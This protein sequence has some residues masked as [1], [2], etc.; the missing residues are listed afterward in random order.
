MYQPP[1]RPLSVA[2]LTSSLLILPACSGGAAPAFEVPWPHSMAG[3]DGAL[4]EAL[5]EAR[6]VVLASPADAASWV[7][8]GMLFEAHLQL[9][10]AESCYGE[11]VRLDGAA[12][13]S[14]YR[15]AAMRGK[16]G[17]VAEALDALARV[18]ALEPGYGPAWRRKGWLLLADG[19]PDEAK[20]AFERAASLDPTDSVAQ[21]GQV[22]SEL[23]VGDA[24][25]A[26]ARL[27]RLE[28]I[29]PSSQA[30]YHRL[31]GRA[32][33]GLG[34]F[35]EAEPELA[36]GR[37]A[38][39]GG[40]DPWMREVNALKIGE[41]AILLRAERMI[42][43]GQAAAAV[44]LLGGLE[45]RD[46]DD[47]RVF[48]RKGR[49]LARIGDWP[50]AA[51]ALSRASELDPGDLGLALASA[52][53][54]VNAND[55]A[56]A[57]RAAE[58]LVVIDPGLADAHALRVELLLGMSR[59]QEAAAAV[60]AARS[61]GVEEASIEVLGGKAAL[62]LQDPRAALEAFGAALALDPASTDALGGKALA[63][64]LTGAVEEAAAS[65]AALR[66]VDPEHPLLPM[67]APAF[68]EALTAGGE[69]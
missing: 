48:K 15:L 42:E 43:G 29:A 32:L 19:R 41:S 14:W 39:V 27:D 10:L 26:L 8:L 60:A 30:F 54:M 50:G 7:R 59:A 21:L 67:L 25:A 20:T 57:L 66:A 47:P 18:E 64:L 34:R 68:D 38:R 35:G 37:G 56:G 55:P 9:E 31:R 1:T 2:L 69:R 33:S 53:A 58:R 63:Q 5:E 13:R 65:A 12:A 22:E 4:V 46:P 3:Y 51:A 62:E 45:A 6:G 44:E 61:S 28:G 23:E 49:A 11:A 16:N 36:R 17:R 40:A 52:S 24:R